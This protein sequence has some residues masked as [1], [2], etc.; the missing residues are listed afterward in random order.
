MEL[1]IRFLVLLLLMVI[2]LLAILTL[3]NPIQSGSSTIQQ[4][5]ERNSACSNW[6]MDDCEP[7]SKYLE[8]V[9]KVFGCFGAED[10]KNKCSNIKYCL[11]SK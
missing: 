9:A 2:A 11:T 3:L 8:N 10:C 7:S 5:A 6:S 1:P 4:T